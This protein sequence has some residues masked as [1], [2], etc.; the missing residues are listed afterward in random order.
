MKRSIVFAGCARDC[1]PYLALVLENCER[2]ATTADRAFFVF[3]END[4]ADATKAILN[5]WAAARDNVKILNFDGLDAHISKRTER[6]AFVRNR[7]LETVRELNL[8]DFDT[9]CMMDCDE[10][11]AKEIAPADFEAAADFLFSSPDHSGVFAVSDPIYYDIYALRHPQWS[12][13]DCWKAFRQAPQERRPEVFQAL[14]CDRQ[15]PIDR[16]QAPI[17]VDSA[18]G[19]LALYRLSHALCARYVGLDSDGDETCEHVAFNV[20]VREQGGKLYVLPQLRN[21]TPWVHC[22]NGRAQKTMHFGN[23]ARKIE[24][25]AP[26]SHQLDHYLKTYPLYDRRLPLLLNV[27]NQIAGDA[28]V[29]DIGANILDTIALMWLSNVRL[30]NSISVDAS[31]E[32]YKYAKL[33]AERHP[34]YA[35][36]CDILW[37]FAGEEKDRGNIA[38]I[39]GTGNVR[40]LR[41]HEQF[42][43]LLKPKHVSFA[44]LAPD[45]VD[46]VKTDLDGYDQIVIQENMTWLKRWKPILWAEAQIESGADLAAWSK[47]LLALAEEFPYVAAFDNFGFCLCAGTML[48][49]WNVV[50]DLIGLGA[51]Y[52]AHQASAGQPRFYYLDIL[53][54]PQRFAAVF[55]E[56]IGRISELR[57]TAAPGDTTVAPARMDHAQTG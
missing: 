39:N 21:T 30:K 8:D 13:G 36:H 2:L 28:S 56:F 17:E 49:K 53:L 9:L 57:M 52:K 26:Q 12:P 48:D 11:N 29:L 25:I 45:G 27:F 7:I 38:P 14:V 44:G 15:I 47:N 6:I 55:D 31:L 32:F 42:E 18:F 20:D 54:V 22:L 24:L 5:S 37:G 10:V 51:R 1:E 3:A 43:S 35:R 33:N 50:L 23:G 16:H 4:S 19:G 46:V 40:E 34:A 41:H